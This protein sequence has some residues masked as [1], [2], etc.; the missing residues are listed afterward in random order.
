MTEGIL[1][2]A[3]EI[4]LTNV[5][6]GIIPVGQMEERIWKK[7]SQIMTAFLRNNWVRYVEALT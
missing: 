7:G 4:F 1:M 6:K 3:D 5:V 2:E